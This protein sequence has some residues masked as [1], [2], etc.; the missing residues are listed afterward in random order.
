MS[1][2]THYHLELSGEIATLHLAG[3]VGEDSAHALLELCR[4][5][6]LHIRTLRLD[7]RGLGAMSAGALGTTR[8]LLQDWRDSRH[9]EFRLS[10]SYLQATYRELEPARAPRSA[11]SVTRSLREPAAASCP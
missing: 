1:D 5:L 11:V 3:M 4:A 8:L 9:G 6:P 2:R 10:T 7:L